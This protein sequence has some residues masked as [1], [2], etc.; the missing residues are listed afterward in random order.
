MATAKNWD[1]AK[2]AAR[3]RMLYN[4]REHGWDDVMAKA[5]ADPQRAPQADHE[6]ARLDLL[7][8]LV[9]RAFRTAA[10]FEEA[11]RATAAEPHVAEAPY[12]LERYRS[13]KLKAGED[14][15][16]DVYRTL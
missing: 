8:P 11:V 5:L 4:S 3:L 15:I 1:A 6:L 2:V 7:T 12:D 16:V 9:A 10:L 14:L 13:F